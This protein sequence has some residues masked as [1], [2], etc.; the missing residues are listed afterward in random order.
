[1]FT[2]EQTS[3]L[4]SP[5]RWLARIIYDAAKELSN[6]RAEILRDART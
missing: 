6:E 5:L 1:M 4:G 2:G 3:L